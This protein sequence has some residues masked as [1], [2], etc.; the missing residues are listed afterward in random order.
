[1]RLSELM[2]ASL[3]DCLDLRLPSQMTIEGMRP[4]ARLHMT[5][6][7]ILRPRTK[8]PVVESCQINGSGLCVLGSFK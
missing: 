5:M 6:V 3:A 7:Q 4:L 8:I 2:L 1:M